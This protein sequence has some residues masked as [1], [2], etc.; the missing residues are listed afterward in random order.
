M[1]A[2]IYASKIEFNVLI[3]SHFFLAKASVAKGGKMEAYA[4]PGL[5]YVDIPNAQIRKVNFSS[6]ILLVIF[7]LF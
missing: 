3:V 2:S 6:T 4:T 1:L 7:F 5:G